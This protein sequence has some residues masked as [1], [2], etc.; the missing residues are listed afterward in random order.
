MDT[1]HHFQFFLQQVLLEIQFAIFCDSN[2][3]IL[4]IQLPVDI[5]RY[6]MNSCALWILPSRGT[7]AFWWLFMSGDA[8]QGDF[9]Q[10]LS[11]SLDLPGVTPEKR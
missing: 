9:R 8:H 10:I 5:N 1:G 3:L 11:E 7:W 2:S 4:T 6:D